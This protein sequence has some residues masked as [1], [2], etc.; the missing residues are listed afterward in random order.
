[1]VMFLNG[2]CRHEL[3]PDNVSVELIFLN[4]VC[5]HELVYVCL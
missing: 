5:R 2:V 4:G 3:H 1:M